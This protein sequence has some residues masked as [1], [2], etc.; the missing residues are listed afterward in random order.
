MNESVWQKTSAPR[1]ARHNVP[2]HVDVVVIGG[3]ITGLSAAWFL[4]QAGKSVCVLERDRIGSG[5]TGHTTAHVTAVTDLRIGK[6]V[7]VFGEAAAKLVWQAGTTAIDAIE[8]IAGGAEI[9]CEFQRVPGFLHASLVAHKDERKQLESEAELATGLGIPAM[10]VS[11][12][13]LVKRPGI[14][15]ANQAKFHPLEYLKG[16]AKAVHGDGCLILQ[17]SEV[18]EVETEPL[19]VKAGR[20]H[21]ACDD[22]VIATHVPLMGIAGL[23]GAAL[24]QTKLYPYS[25]YV[26]SASLPRGSLP[27]VSLWDTSDPYFYLRVD[28]G[29]KADRI[30]FGGEDHKTGQAG[31]T[32]ACFQKLEAVLRQILPDAKVLLRW[33]GQVVETNDGLP[34]I[35]DTA[36]HQFVATGF[37]GNGITFGTLAGMMARDRICGR[38][39]PWQELFAVN[40][41]KLR[42]GTWSYLSEN[43]DYPY[44]FLKD[45]L[46]GGEAES[47]RAV[48]RGEGQVLKLDGQ[49][50]A[51]SRDA[52]G[53]ATMLSAVC[54]HM[55]CLVRWNAAEHTWDCPCHGSRFRPDGQVLAGPAEDP[56][57][58]FEAKGQAREQPQQINGR[59]R[60]R[61]R[62][63]SAAPG[64]DRK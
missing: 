42:G 56:L 32:N 55:G 27:E 23:A 28:R 6:L 41:K 40:R 60:K 37:A 21:I 44:Y 5:D 61:P 57:Q 8:H 7:K 33:S 29:R 64:K 49:H 38:K 45:R 36:E 15:F 39:N 30:I 16:L 12:A 50:V 34:Y 26:V 48:R 20:L 62:R 14:R 54:T 24:F 52:Q 53:K 51:C 31:D 46:S 35:G 18:D 63:R 10:F 58:P 9:N 4:K 22:L 1:F 43:V 19:A 3:G 59:T 13:P 11:E 47:T 2:D 17:N 25:S